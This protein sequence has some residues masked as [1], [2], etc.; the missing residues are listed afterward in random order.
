M[1]RDVFRLQANLAAAR[2]AVA[3]GWVE[4]DIYRTVYVVFLGECG[5]MREI[6]RCDDL[7]IK[8][9]RTVENVWVYKPE[10]KRLKQKILLPFGSC[11]L[12]PVYARTG[13]FFLFSIFHKNTLSFFFYFIYHFP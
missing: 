13:S 9:D 12:A 7:V 5:A 10:I 1:S 4:E 8:D 6:F 3:S 2:V 11:Q